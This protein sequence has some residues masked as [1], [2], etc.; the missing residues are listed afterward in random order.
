MGLHDVKPLL[1]PLVGS[2]GERA[3]WPESVG[4]LAYHNTATLRLFP[5]NYLRLH[6]EGL[7]P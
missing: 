4:K 5:V 2:F 7:D 6:T 1:L 3:F